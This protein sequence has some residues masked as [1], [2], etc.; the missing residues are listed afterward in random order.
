MWTCKYFVSILN[1][2]VDVIY[3]LDVISVSNHNIL[4]IYIGLLFLTHQSTMYINI[5]ENIT[6]YRNSTYKMGVLCFN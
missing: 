1:S 3:V 2:R 4:Y 6:I 5:G